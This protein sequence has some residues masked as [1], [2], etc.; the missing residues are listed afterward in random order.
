[1]I[2]TL[3]IRFSQIVFGAIA[4]G[5]SITAIKW[6]WTGTAP[7]TTS[8]SAFAGAFGMLTAVIGTVAV[9]L[10]AIPGIIMAMV[11][12]LASLIFLAGG[13]VSDAVW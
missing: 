6:Q 4:L 2:V 5:L 1:M 12:G 3:V 10:D 9:F 7:A 13:I 8:Y 11:D